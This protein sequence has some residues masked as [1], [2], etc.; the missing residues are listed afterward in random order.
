MMPIL[1]RSKRLQLKP[2]TELC[3][4]LVHY[5]DGV[6]RDTQTAG[7][8]RTP[9]KGFSVATECGFGRRDPATIP[10]LLRI[11]AEICR[12]EAGWYARAAFV[13]IWDFRQP[14]L[15]GTI[16]SRVMAYDDGAASNPVQSW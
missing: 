9:C 4:G 7:D 13:T 6:C 15:D 10:D 14:I 11:H 3:L 1:R 8:R 12:T 5:T 16:W 2:E